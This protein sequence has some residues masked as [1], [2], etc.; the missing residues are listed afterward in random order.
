MEESVSKNEMGV[1]WWIT[2]LHMYGNTAVRSETGDTPMIFAAAEGRLDI[3]T[4]LLQH[5]ADVDGQNTEY[6]DTAL[7][8][9]ADRGFTDIALALIESGA[10]MNVMS[11][12]RRPLPAEKTLFRSFWKHE[13]DSASGFTALMFAVHGGYKSRE[14]AVALV[15]AGADIDTQSI[16]CGHTAL[17]LTTA[18]DNCNVEVLKCLLERGADVHIKNNRGETALL[19]CTRH[20]SAV[21]ALWA[22]TKAGADVNVKDS[23]GNT[24]LMLAT[25]SSRACPGIELPLLDHGA[26][27]DET[28]QSGNTPLLEAISRC[29]TKIALS[30][31]KSGACVNV[32]GAGAAGESPLTVAVKRGLRDVVG[33]LVDNGADINFQNSRHGATPLFL[34]IEAGHMDM[35]QYLIDQGADVNIVSDNKTSPLLLAVMKNRISLADTLIEKGADLESD[36]W[37]GSTILMY[38]IMCNMYDFAIKL[39]HLGANVNAVSAKGDNPLILAAEYGCDAMLFQFLT[40]QGSKWR[41]DLNAKNF[42]GDTALLMAI[43][44]GHCRLAECL[45]KRRGIAVDVV[46]ANTGDTALTLAVKAGY[47]DVAQSLI[48]KG[49]NIDITNHAG[50]SAMI[51]AALKGQVYNIMSS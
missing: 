45:I 8:V 48:D 30:L 1:F 51:L 36:T 21:E 6:G 14:I 38:A 13:I 39:L 24:P 12:G 9:A 23:R 11:V 18:E 25:S 2:T 46:D 44:K 40:L 28:N 29:N 43:K 26:N 10:D 34:A 4:G 19:I 17:M 15:C 33:V 22:L 31:V 47:T 49:A 42:N 37:D 32:K 7:M 3:V 50:E 35:V 16:P 5:G 41:A 20:G 27:I